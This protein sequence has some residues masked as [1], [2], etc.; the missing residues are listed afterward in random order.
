MTK[1]H[2]NENNKKA[3]QKINKINDIAFVELSL[4]LA[5][6]LVLLEY[7]YLILIWFNLA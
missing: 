5:V 2:R 1:E 4:W 7:F 3:V 6:F